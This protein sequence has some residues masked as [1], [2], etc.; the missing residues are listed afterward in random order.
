MITTP[1]APTAA[2]AAFARQAMDAPETL[3]GANA[4]A[5]FRLPVG[6]PDPT[7]RGQLRVIRDDSR[8]GWHAVTLIHADCP[9]LSYP[10]FDTLNNNLMD[11]SVLAISVTTR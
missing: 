11:P 3:D 9:L 5:T 2:R 8:P 7:I 6:G 10:I 1:R 4:T